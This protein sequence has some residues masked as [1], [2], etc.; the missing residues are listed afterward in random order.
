MSIA[1]YG[2]RLILCVP[3]TLSF[4][5]FRVQNGQYRVQIPCTLTGPNVRNSLKPI[6]GGF[7]NR[8]KSF[9][10]IWSNCCLMVDNSLT[11]QVIQYGS[12]LLS[13]YKSHNCICLLR[14][15]PGDCNRNL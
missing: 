5:E 3:V 15:G 1:L 4:G 12:S 7:T 8:V 2:L 10:T 6:A 14:S 13:G 11:R 9:G